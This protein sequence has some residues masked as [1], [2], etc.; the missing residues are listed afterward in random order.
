MEGH[1]S[2]KCSILVS[3]IDNGGGPVGVGAGDIWEISVPASQFCYEP[4]KLSLKKKS[5]ILMFLLIS[6][7]LFPWTWVI[8][9]SKTVSF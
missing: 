2:N 4:K 5:W 6:C 7:H 1:Q 3:D 9:K 8:M